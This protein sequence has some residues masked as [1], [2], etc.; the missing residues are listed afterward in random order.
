MGPS[1]ACQEP[2]A[3]RLRHRA[4]STAFMDCCS[5]A[6]PLQ[7][8]PWSIATLN[9]LSRSAAGLVQTTTLDDCPTDKL[10]S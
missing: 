1:F 9:L 5:A 6:E 4:L 10:T 8:H 7:V 3:L 2:N